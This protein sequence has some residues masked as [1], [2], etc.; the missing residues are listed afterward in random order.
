M[1]C[2]YLFSL[3][4]CFGWEKSCQNCSRTCKLWRPVSILEELAIWMHV[5]MK[6]SSFIQLNLLQYCTVCTFLGSISFMP[7]D[8]GR[9][10]NKTCFPLTPPSQFPTYQVPPPQSIPSAPDCPI[11]LFSTIATSGLLLDGFLKPI[12]SVICFKGRPNN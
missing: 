3:C 8:V 7:M 4:Q 12:T 9:N 5:C 6:Y 10:F 2:L 11:P 1:K